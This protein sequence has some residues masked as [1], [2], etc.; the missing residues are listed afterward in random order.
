M[1]FD[2]NNLKKDEYRGEMGKLPVCQFL[3]SKGP[4][5]QTGI[6]GD[7]PILFLKDTKLAG[8]LNPEYG[9]PYKHVYKGGDT[10][11]GIIFEDF[12][13][14]V[15]NKSP[16]LIEVTLKGEEAGIG[17]RGQV[18]GVFDQPGGYDLRSNFPKEYTTL[19]TLYLLYF[20]DQQ[21][22]FLHKMPYSLSVHGG[23]A[24][25]FG[26][27]LDNFYSLLESAYSN[28]NY[29]N[30]QYLTLSPEARS[31]GV[32][33]AYLTK[34]QVGEGNTI[35]DVASVGDFKRPTPETIDEFF[36]S[37]FADQIFAT[38]KSMS[39]F[40]DK[41]LKQFEQFHPNPGNL[42][43]GDVD[44]E[45]GEIYPPVKPLLTGDV[46]NLYA[47]VKQ[48]NLKALQRDVEDDFDYPPY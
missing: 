13:C 47:K 36:N 7:L 37:K 32:F 45:T 12:R 16:R 4:K 17:K 30:G 11:E 8:W 27:S 35:A 34:Q 20:L 26:S 21:N 28:S 43:L 29:G 41:Y 48:S 2:L 22:N 23:A 46:E 42:A 40:A 10:E 31:L 3:I 24:Y 1:V 44:Q 25:H 19:R 15:I 5:K 33:H 9:V 18:L 14:N 39:G 38:R 6:E